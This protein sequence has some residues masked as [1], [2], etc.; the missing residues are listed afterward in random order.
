MIEVNIPGRQ[1][2]RFEY[3]VLD[4]NGTIALDGEV[5]P[6][7]EERWEVLRDNIIVTIV[8]ADIHGNAE[9]IG[10]SLEVK[11][12]RINAGS[13]DTQKSEL[14]NELGREHTVCIGNGTNDVSML[15]EA[16]LGICV[17]GHEG[18]SVE[19]V[20]S[21]DLVVHDINHALDLLLHPDRLVA[22]LR[23]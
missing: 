5:I 13:E 14:V 8:T 21:A 23:K 22:T 20:M 2:N 3:L 6:G 11:I 10:Q 4:L 1:T 18:A 7:V 16:A 17:I 15:K 9:V 12:H 19:A